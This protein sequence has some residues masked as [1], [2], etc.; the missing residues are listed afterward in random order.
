MYC[1]NECTIK[2]VKVARLNESVCERV[3][4][5]LRDGGGVCGTRSH[6]DYSK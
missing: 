2:I 5:V 3:V 6:E 4:V 1:K